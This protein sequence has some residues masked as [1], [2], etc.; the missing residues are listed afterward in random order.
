MFQLS[1][2]LIVF[3]HYIYSNVSFHFQC[4]DILSLF[5]GQLVTNGLDR[6]MPGGA[7]LLAGCVVCVSFWCVWGLY[8]GLNVFVCRA[9]CAKICEVVF[10]CIVLIC[11]LAR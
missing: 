4:W 10:V 2:V 11:V 9:G 7:G 5:F 6:W 1:I 8:S 3:R